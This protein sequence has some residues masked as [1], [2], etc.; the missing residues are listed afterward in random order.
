M[1]YNISTDGTLTLENHTA[2]NGINLTRAMHLKDRHSESHFHSVET[3]SRDKQLLYVP[4]LGDD[5]IK[6]FE[7]DAAGKFHQRKSYKVDTKEKTHGPRYIVFS[8]IHKCAY[9][10][11]LIIKMSKN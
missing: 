8:D 11:T 10:E 4:D 5:I 7:Y 3:S 9:R 1:S 6:T 2:G